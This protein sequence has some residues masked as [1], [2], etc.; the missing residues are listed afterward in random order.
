[1][2][3]PVLGFGLGLVHVITGPDH[4][5]AV[6]PLSV[7]GRESAWRTGLRWGVGHSTGVALIGGLALALRE[8]LPMDA[9]SSWS[10]RVIGLT[11][12]GIGAWGLMRVFGRRVDVGEHRHGDVAHAH[13]RVSSNHSHAALAVGT[14]HGLAGSSHLFGVLPALALPTRVDSVL[15]LAGFA[16]G[17]IVAM[18]LFAQVVGSLGKQRVKPLLATTSFVALGVGVWWLSGLPTL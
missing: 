14:L 16:L 1:M 11:L 18:A 6:A 10:E 9:I 5:A 15:Y 17:T 4:L 7:G 3:A 13:P 2:F 8:V 12:I